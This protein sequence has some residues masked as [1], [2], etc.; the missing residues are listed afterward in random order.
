MTRAA[1]AVLRVDGLAL[2]GAAW[3]IEERKSVLTSANTSMVDGILPV[4]VVLRRGRCRSS[5]LYLSQKI[6]E[7]AAA[8]RANVGETRNKSHGHSSGL[9]HTRCNRADRYPLCP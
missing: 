3:T 6:A 2:R 1:D 5:A 7:K 4:S 8:P 9:M